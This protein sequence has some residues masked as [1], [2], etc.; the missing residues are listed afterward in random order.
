MSTKYKT[1]GAGG[2]VNNTLVR[3]GMNTLRTTRRNKRNSMKN[4]WKD[5]AR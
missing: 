3:S 5:K 4:I 1:K 2:G